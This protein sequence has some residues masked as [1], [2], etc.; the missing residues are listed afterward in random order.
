[1]DNT[2]RLTTSN[3]PPRDLE[4]EP[5]KGVCNATEPPCQ[6]SLGASLRSASD[7]RRPRIVLQSERVGIRAAR[8]K[9]VPGA[10]LACL[11]DWK[12]RP[13][14][15][16]LAV[17]ATCD[18]VGTRSLGSVGHAGKGTIQHQLA[19]RY[20]S[21]GHLPSPRERTLRRLASNS[22]GSSRARQ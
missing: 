11:P 16:V 19:C 5:D 2:K 8:W 1:M 13:S 22:I 9:T 4:R 10:T 15:R 6:R 21:A 3:I 17:D 20:R 18:P 12:E 14:N 7:A